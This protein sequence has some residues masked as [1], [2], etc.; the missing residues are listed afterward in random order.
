MV[1]M[2][3]ST[4]RRDR[5][6]SASRRGD[7]VKGDPSGHKMI[8]FPLKVPVCESAVVL[9]AAQL[10]CSSQP[11]TKIQPR[12]CFYVSYHVCRPILTHSIPLNQFSHNFRSSYDKSSANRFKCEPSW[13][14]TGGTDGAISRGVWPSL[15]HCQV[16]G[17]Q[18]FSWHS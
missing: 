14:V 13:Q 18:T 16:H 4:K 12:G 1:H 9:T 15:S 10:G 6:Y 2:S 7:Q 5:L 3:V 8:P 17:V 11:Q